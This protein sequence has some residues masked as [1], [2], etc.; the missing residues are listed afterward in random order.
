MDR[1][2]LVHGGYDGVRELA[3]GEVLDITTGVWRDL[4]AAGGFAG[5]AADRDGLRTWGDGTPPP[6]LPQHLVRPFTSPNS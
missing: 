3:D 2:L 5:G 1:Y 4:A 6:P